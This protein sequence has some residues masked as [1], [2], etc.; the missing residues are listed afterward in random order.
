MTRGDADQPARLEGEAD[1]GD[2]DA[3]L[4]SE[5]KHGDRGPA[6]R[7]LYGRGQRRG[8]G[9]PSEHEDLAGSGSRERALPGALDLEGGAPSLH[10]EVAD[11]HVEEV[12][13]CPTDLRRLDRTSGNS[14]SADIEPSG[15]EQGVEPG[16]AGRGRIE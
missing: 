9:V 7:R 1:P 3:Q 15:A 5:P 13:E 6:E 4:H 11:G 2:L 8:D 14:E 12:K 10:G 16:S